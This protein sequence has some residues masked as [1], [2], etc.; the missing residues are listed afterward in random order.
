MSKIKNCDMCGGSYINGFLKWYRYD[1]GTQ[2]CE[3]VCELCADL[4]DRLLKVQYIPIAH[5]LGGGRQG[6]AKVAHSEKAQK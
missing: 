2:F 1:N 3:S 4:H 5:R 6:W